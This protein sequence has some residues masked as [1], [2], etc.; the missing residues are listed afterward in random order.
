MSSATLDHEEKE[1]EFPLEN[2]STISDRVAHHERFLKLSELL[3][4][5]KSR[6]A[7][8]FALQTTRDVVAFYDVVDIFRST[9]DSNTRLHMAK[10]AIGTY[11]VPVKKLPMISSSIRDHLIGIYGKGDQHS[12]M[13]A[14]CFDFALEDMIRY[15]CDLPKFS[16]YLERRQQ[17]QLREASSSAAASQASTERPKSL[18]LWRWIRRN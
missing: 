9:I 1:Q 14:E 8:F 13:D 4:D 11:I 16:Q 10:V 7:V 12:L 15:L 6:Q 17:Q 18:L 3:V 5:K 2:D